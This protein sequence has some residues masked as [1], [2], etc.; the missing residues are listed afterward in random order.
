MSVE[1]VIT[2]LSVAMFMWTKW[3]DDWSGREEST[4]EKK[5]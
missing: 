1:K 2:W 4:V 3:L 5:E